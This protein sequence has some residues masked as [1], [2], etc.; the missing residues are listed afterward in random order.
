[1]AQINS[2]TLSLSSAN[3]PTSTPNQYGITNGTFTNMRFDNI[4]MRNLLGDLYGKYNRFN[5][6]LVA[7]MCSSGNSSGGGGDTNLIVKV[8]GLNFINNGYEDI[9]GNSTGFVTAGYSMRGGS[10]VPSI[11]H[12]QNVYNTFAYS[13]EIV[14][15]SIKIYNSYNAQ[16]TA[17]YGRS[18]FLFVITPIA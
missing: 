12:V 1:M 10:S 18:N 17:A 15:I 11:T 5:I 3:L 6:S 2:V 8:S 13:T 14:S 9:I 16:S 7:E 4:N